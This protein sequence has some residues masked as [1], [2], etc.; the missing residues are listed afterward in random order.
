MAHDPPAIKQSQSDFPEV[1]IFEEANYWNT[2]YNFK[3]F[4]N[5]SKN[6]LFVVSHS[7]LDFKNGL[8]IQPTKILEDYIISRS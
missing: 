3:L 2:G 7:N 1:T 8:L 6:N 5:S 4:K